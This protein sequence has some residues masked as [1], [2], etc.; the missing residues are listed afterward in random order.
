MWEYF[1]ELLSVLNIIFFSL[2]LLVKW[3]E[4]DNT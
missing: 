2:I 1:I 3:V 4:K